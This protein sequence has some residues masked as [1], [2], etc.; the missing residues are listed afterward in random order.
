MSW[1]KEELVKEAFSVLA[2][3]GFT[4]DLSPEMLQMGLRRLDTMLAT[5]NGKGIRLG[6]P[7]PASPS[8]SK[9]NDDS[10]LPDAAVE[11]VYLNAAIRIASSL[12]KTIPGDVRLSA[13]AGYD[14]LAA[15]AAMPS[16]QQFPST[17]PK[18]AGNKITRTRRP[19]MPPPDDPI[20]AGDDGVIDFQ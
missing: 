6:Y 20:V 14:V 17:M 15:R 8:D 13:K 19:F 9:L 3:S 5:W 12:G 10:N 4:F 1:T 11:A 2:L 7:L 16:E 18:G